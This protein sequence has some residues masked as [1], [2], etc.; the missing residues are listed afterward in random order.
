[1]E[2]A[3]IPEEVKCKCGIPIPVQIMDKIDRKASDAL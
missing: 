1:M 3:N 2:N